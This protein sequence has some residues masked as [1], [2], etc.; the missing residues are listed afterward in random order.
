MRVKRLDVT[1]PTFHKKNNG[2]RYAEYFQKNI[3]ISN[4]RISPISYNGIANSINF[5][6]FLNWFERCFAK[7]NEQNVTTFHICKLLGSFWHMR[8]D[9]LSSRS[10]LINETNLIQLGR[11]TELKAL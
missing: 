5:L 2:F 4:C 10:T 9:R 8:F 6:V 3:L 1:Q 11:T 7:D